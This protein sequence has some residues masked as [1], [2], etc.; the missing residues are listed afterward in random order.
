M[1]RSTQRTHRWWFPLKCTFYSIHRLVR[2]GD[3][4]RKKLPDSYAQKAF[5]RRSS[6]VYEFIIVTNVFDARKP[7]KGVSLY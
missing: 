2:E 5:V 3:A 1:D 4:A 6:S 7:L